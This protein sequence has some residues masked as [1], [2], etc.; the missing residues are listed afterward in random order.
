MGPQ[1]EL[2][3]QRGGGKEGLRGGWDARERG[4][5]TSREVPRVAAA[6]LEVCLSYKQATLINVLAVVACSQVPSIQPGFIST[7]SG[8]GWVSRAGK[9]P[10]RDPTGERK[11]ETKSSICS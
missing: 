6:L 5:W 11:C 2:G 1:S 7:R 10:R 9:W 3:K 8:T 4:L